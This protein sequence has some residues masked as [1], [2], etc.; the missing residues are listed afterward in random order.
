MELMGSSPTA[1]EAAQGRWITEL[2]ADNAALS[3]EVTALRKR[4]PDPPAVLQ[5]LVALVTAPGAHEPDLL[6]QV[7]QLVCM[8]RH[9]AKCAADLPADPEGVLGTFA[10]TVPTGTI[11]ITRDAFTKCAGLAQ[12]SLPATVTVIAQGNGHDGGAFSDCTSLSEIT[13]P[14]NLTKIGGYAFQECTSLGD[15]T[16]PA[17]PVDVGVDAFRDCPGTPRRPGD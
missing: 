10:V 16:L 5:Q 9:I 2:E 17:G 8:P 6:D 15:I 13:L 7:C 3:V 12:V 14:P 1:R 11:A 4:L